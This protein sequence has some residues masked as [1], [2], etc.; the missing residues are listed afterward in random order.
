MSKDNLILHKT[1]GVNPHMTFCPRCHAE[2][3]ELLLLGHVDHVHVCKG[4]GLAHLENT[5]PR[6]CRNSRCQ[7][8]NFESRKLGDNERLPASEPC[9]ACKTELAEH[10]AVV[11]AGGVY[12]RC[13]DCKGHGVIKGTNEFAISVR[14]AHKLE[15]PAPCGVEFSKEDCPA[16]A[17]QQK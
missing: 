4:C 16:C 3:N 2:A 6:M 11:D 17:Q 13:T 5:A 9:D 12:W 7:N 14:K 8:G 10:K 1:K 15:A